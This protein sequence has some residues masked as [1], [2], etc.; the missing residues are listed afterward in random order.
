MSSKSKWW[1]Y[2]PVVAVVAAC[3]SSSGSGPATSSPTTSG[4]TTSSPAT[5]SP[6]SSAAT[7]TSPTPSSA[8]ATSAA[9]S[10]SA[11][12]S[13]TVYAPVIDPASFTDQ[14]T[15]RYSPF[16]PGTTWVYDGTSDGEQEHNVVTVTTDTKLVMGVS[17]VVVHDVVFAS[18]AKAEETF[19]WYAQD[20]DGAVWYFGEDS[21]EFDESGAVTSTSGSWEAGINGAMPGI[22]MLAQPAVGDTYREE[23]LPGEA[24]DTAKVLQTDASASVTA[25]SYDHVVVIEDTTPLEP[26]IVEHKSFAPGVGVVSE[27]MVAGGQEHSELTTVTPT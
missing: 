9:S 1:L 22:V 19:D 26:T 6:A 3:G 27:D 7:T 4:P 11:P 24:E 20:A 21:K 18:G 5:S 15:N 10:P 14:V 17:C 25:G 16:V 23:Y 2:G 13:T 8:I 12:D